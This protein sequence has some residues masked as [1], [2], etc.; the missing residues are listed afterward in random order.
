MNLT[1]Q[2]IDAAYTALSHAKTAAEAATERALKRQAELTDAVDQLFATG[3]ITGRT[4]SS[5]SENG[6]CS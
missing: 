5:A 2:T 6:A 1:E 3:K 4:N